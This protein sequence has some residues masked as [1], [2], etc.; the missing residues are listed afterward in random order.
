MP[1]DPSTEFYSYLSSSAHDT[2]GETNSVVPASSVKTHKAEKSEKK[3]DT[4]QDQDANN[5]LVPPQTES[6]PQASPLV[7]LLG[8]PTTQTV[9]VDET[10]KATQDSGKAVLPLT[11]TQTK[12]DISQPAPKDDHNRNTGP[13]IAS[14]ALPVSFV[15]QPGDTS[16]VEEASKVD[17]VNTPSN[18][19]VNDASGNDSQLQSAGA[20]AKDA[21]PASTPGNW[22]FALRLSEG[23]LKSEFE[24]TLQRVDSA[25]PAASG[26]A[27]NTLNSIA[28]TVVQAAAGSEL[29]EQSHERDNSFGQNLYEVPPTQPQKADDT[30]QAANEQPVH[31]TATDFEARQDTAGSEPVRNVHM[32]VIG[33]NNNRVDIR[34]IDRGGELHVSVKSEDLNLAKGLQDH[35]PELTSRLEQSRF[36]A[37]VWMPKLSEV[38]KPEMS[39]ARDFSSDGNNGSNNSSTYSDQQRKGQQG[40]QPDWVDVLENSTRG[41]GRTNQ[42]WLQ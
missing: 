25:E 34:M 41:A 30:P 8:L 7:A 19:S 4:S 37:E 26:V 31:T 36:Q 11:N 27:G 15:P 13:V 32:Q 23:D 28:A 6:M 9:D 21:A 3:T 38:V 18:T 20:S 24:E 22:A 16:N 14:A 35:M 33:D 40:N 42:T 5:V 29:K 17:P 39:G 2:N 10:G 1:G 12:T